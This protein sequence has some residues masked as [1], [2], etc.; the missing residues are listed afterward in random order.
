MPLPPE[1][2]AEIQERMR[3]AKERLDDIEE[4]IRDLRAAG[5]DAS[6]H[7]EQAKQLRERLN[8]WSI[9]YGLQSKKA[10]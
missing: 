6:R 2:L 8:Q 3:A 5:I 1:K 7:E 10:G 4:T 9:F